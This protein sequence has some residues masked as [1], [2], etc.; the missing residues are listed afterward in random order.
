MR[1]WQVWKWVCRTRLVIP[2]TSEL[3]W[4]W[5]YHNH[6]RS[7]QVRHGYGW[8]FITV[9]SKDSCIQSVVGLGP[10][11]SVIILG[12]C[13]T[14][15]GKRERAAQW[16]GKVAEFEQ[17]QNRCCQHS[18]D[19]QTE[20]IWPLTWYCITLFCFN[21]H[22]QYFELCVWV[23]NVLALSQSYKF[24]CVPVR[25]C[26]CCMWNVCMHLYWMY[27]FR[28]CVILH[29]Q[30]IYGLVSMWCECNFL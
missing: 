22:L 18:Y 10:P 21:Y 24:P 8:A 25:P 29:A 15:W 27:M 13:R 23:D 26:S 11:T 30:I 3:T 20:S 1:G 6:N 19:Q 14:L 9:N 5:C 4:P 2:V 16:F 17:G 7:I 28:T 12:E